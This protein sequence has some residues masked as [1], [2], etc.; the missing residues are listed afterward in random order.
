MEPISLILTALV[1]GAG[2]AT[3]GSLVKDIY[4][5]LKALIKRKFADNSLANMIL[6]EHEKNPKTYQEPLKEKLIEGG[7]DKDEEVIKK[8]EELL[9]KLK[10]EEAATGLNIKVSG[11]V[12]GSIGD[13]TNIKAGVIGDISGGKINQ[14]F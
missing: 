14:T 12:K 2:E 9:E 3:A 13:K 4:Q 5:N 7:I 10:S 8:A 6:E 11:D 1:T